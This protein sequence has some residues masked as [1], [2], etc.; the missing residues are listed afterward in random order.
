ML[1]DH[2]VDEAMSSATVDYIAW[3]EIQVL[4]TNYFDKIY[5]TLNF[6]WKITRHS[7]IES[8]VLPEGHKYH[9]VLLKQ[10]SKLST[11]DKENSGSFEEGRGCIHQ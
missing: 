2:A 11:H 6:A 9:Y 1:V 10:V 8:F 7:S 5:Y 4:L 3:R